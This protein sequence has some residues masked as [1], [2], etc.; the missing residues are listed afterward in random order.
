MSNLTWN[1]SSARNF[2]ISYIDLTV[3]TH[4]LLYKNA[5][6]IMFIKIEQLKFYVEVHN[7]LK[8]NIEACCISVVS[9]NF[10]ILFTHY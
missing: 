8:N 4:F 2:N 5:S 10:N 3:S 1:I 7:N 6:C 9:F